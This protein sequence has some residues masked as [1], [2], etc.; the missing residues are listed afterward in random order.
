MSVVGVP[1]ERFGQK[2]QLAEDVAITAIAGGAAL[3]PEEKFVAVGF[4]DEELKDYAYP[5]QREG[6]PEAFAAKLLA[7]RI[8]VHDCRLA[9]E[10]LEG[11]R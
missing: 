9:L 1:D 7:A 11:V 4:T 2:V 6:A 3:L 10:G 5:G 8:A